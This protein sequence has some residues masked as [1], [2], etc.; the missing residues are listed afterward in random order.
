[1]VKTETTNQGH[2]MTNQSEPVI[3]NRYLNERS[4][5]ARSAQAVRVAVASLHGDLGEDTLVAIGQKDQRPLFCVAGEVEDFQDEEL[6]PSTC[7]EVE[8][9]PV[10]L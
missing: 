5:T 10:L 7:T 9:S 3:T 4:I 6:F 1:M 8:V 2:G